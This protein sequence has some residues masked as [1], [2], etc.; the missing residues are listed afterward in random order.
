[1]KKIIIAGSRSLHFGK[2]AVYD[3]LDKLYRQAFD[4]HGWPMSWD[5]PIEVVSGGA[6]GADASGEKFALAHKR[7]GCKL[8]TIPAAWDTYGKA[9]GPVR[10]EQMANYADGALI[11]F[12][13]KPS[14]GSSNMLAWMVLLDKPVK[15]IVL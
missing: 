6:K 8:K 12:K 7:L 9:A 2:C 5:F 13:D 10:N 14:P 1:M 4:T 15:V 11:F 3:G